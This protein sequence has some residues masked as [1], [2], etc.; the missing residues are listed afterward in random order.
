[1]A[2]GRGLLIIADIGGYTRFMRLH[3]LS[4]A[5]A[6]D[7]TSRLLAAVVDSVPQLSLIE[8]EGDA[9]FFYR[10]D[11]KPATAIDLA[12]R[13]CTAFQAKQAQIVALNMCSCDACVQAG[14]LKLKVVAHVGE[15]A[16]QTIGRRKNLVGVDVIAVHLMLKNDVPVPEYVLV[17]EPIYQ[18][19]EAPIRQRAQGIHQDLEG[20]GPTQLY[21]LDVGELPLQLPPPPRATLPR[22]LRETMGVMGRG[23]PYLLGLRPARFAQ[24]PQPTAK[25]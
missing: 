25:P 18:D 23:F 10:A 4:L 16:T 3:R 12:S 8:I 17:S 9:G 5:H 13:M 15:V 20:L 22:R 1:V 7:V 24:G 21:W 19:T 2:A 11:L 6:Q 14:Q